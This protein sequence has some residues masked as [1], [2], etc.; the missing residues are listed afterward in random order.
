M[1]TN[2]EMLFWGTNHIAQN[3]GFKAR[4]DEEI[5]LEDGEVC[6]YGG[7]NIP[8]LADVRFLCEDVGIPK[9]YIESSEMGID[10]YIP[11]DWYEKQAQKEYKGNDFWKRNS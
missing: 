2:L 10:V 11:E 3:H 7:C 9:D 4:A 5:V 1:K 8:V 6:I